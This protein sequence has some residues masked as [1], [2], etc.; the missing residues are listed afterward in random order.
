MILITA[1]RTALKMSGAE[2][3]NTLKKTIPEI[4]W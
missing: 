3:D 2:I 1:N 4:I